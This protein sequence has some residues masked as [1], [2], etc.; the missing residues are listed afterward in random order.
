[1]MITQYTAA[2]LVAESVAEG[3]PISRE[4]VHLEDGRSVRADGLVIAGTIE[5]PKH[6]GRFHL[7]DGSPARAPICRGLTTYQVENRGGRLFMCVTKPGGAG[8]RPQATIPLKV[9]EVRSVATFIREITLEPDSK[10]TFQPGDYL[11]FEITEYNEIRFS[12]LEI[13]EP[14][15]GVWRAQH[16]FDLVARNPDGKKLNNYSLASDPGS[17][18]LLRL[19]VRIATPP[20]G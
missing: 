2:G 18:S 11:Q 20:P 7:T 10:I 12:D 4:L 15:A 3:L 16:V 14:Y 8:A 19:N 6:N 13:P 17:E 9:V 1:M 5:C